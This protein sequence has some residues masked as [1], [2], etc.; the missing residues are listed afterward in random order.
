M[1]YELEGDFDFEFVEGLHRWPPAAGIEETFGTS[2]ICRSYFDGSAESAAAAITNLSHYLVDNGPFHVVIGFSLGAALTA[3]LLLR[4]G[5][6]DDVMWQIK[7]ALFI[8]GTLPCD[9]NQL[10]R[11]KLDFLEA[12]SVGRVIQIP[13]VHAWSVQDVEHPGQSEQLVRM[14]CE[15]TRIEV[16]HRA[17]HSIPYLKEEVLAV[18]NAVRRVVAQ[19]SVQTVGLMTDQ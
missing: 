13:T 18:A 12:D 7:S 11:G 2:Q 17:G 16:L 1:R 9:W 8:C 5:L 10:Q 14:C 19:G 3:S 15:E 6:D 4:P